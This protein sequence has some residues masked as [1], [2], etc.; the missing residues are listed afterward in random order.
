M[1]AMTETCMGENR[2]F[3][4]EVNMGGFLLSGSK[5]WILKRYCRQRRQSKQ[6]QR[7]NKFVQDCSKGLE[8]YLV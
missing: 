4:P 3:L 1:G 8:N 7:E 5:G 2:K 6:G